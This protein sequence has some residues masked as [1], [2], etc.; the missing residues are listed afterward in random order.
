[1][2]PRS[3]LAPQRAAQLPPLAGVRLA[4]G[5]CGV[6]YQGRSDVCLMA[7]APG[8][9]IAGVLTRS[10]CPSAPVQWCRRALRGGRVRAVLVNSGNA[11]AFTGRLGEASVRRCAA[12]AALGCRR[13]E[14]FLASTGVIGEPLPD[15]R[16]TAKLAELSAGLA[17]DAWAEAA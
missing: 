3:P 14:V 10:L 8:T 2:P 4:A 12:A 6:R 17:E 5:A 13:E 9:A 11:N 16:I 15:E 1:M 7:F